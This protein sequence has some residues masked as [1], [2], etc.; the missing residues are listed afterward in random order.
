MATVVPMDYLLTSFKTGWAN[1]N[2]FSG[3]HIKF[4]E[5]QKIIG[6]LLKATI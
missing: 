2:A 4:T 5:T 6:V 3:A 1:S